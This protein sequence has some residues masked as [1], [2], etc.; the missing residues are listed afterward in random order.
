[1]AVYRYKDSENDEKVTSERRE[2]RE[3]RPKCYR[4]LPKKHI[5]SEHPTTVEKWHKNHKNNSEII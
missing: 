1:M 3:I 2:R 4:F 5:Y